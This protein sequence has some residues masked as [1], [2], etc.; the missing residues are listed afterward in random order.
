MEILEANLTTSG[1]SVPVFSISSIFRRYCQFYLECHIN[2]ER[3][4]KRR[5]ESE[6]TGIKRLIYKIGRYQAIFPN[7]ILKKIHCFLI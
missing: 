3:I 2:F 7:C 1:F 4:F 6:K 5:Q